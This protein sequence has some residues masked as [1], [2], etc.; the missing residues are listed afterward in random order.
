ML[1]DLVIGFNSTTLLEAGLRE[2]PIIIPKFD[3]A[4]TL[5]IN[6]KITK[7]F[8]IPPVRYINEPN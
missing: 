1:S 8:T 7:G 6:K 5:G 2:I 3:E 4:N